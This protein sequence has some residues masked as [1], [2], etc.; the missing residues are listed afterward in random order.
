MPNQ[1]F[2]ETLNF[3]R[4]GCWNTE[5]CPHL[6]G[7]YMQLSVIKEPHFWLLADKTVER[8]NAMCDGCSEFHSKGNKKG[9]D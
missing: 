9:N 5:N 6:E 1:A 7:P 3:T 2:T 8:L 4:C